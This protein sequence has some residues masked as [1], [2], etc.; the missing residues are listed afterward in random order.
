MDADYDWLLAAASV[1]KNPLSAQMWSTSG[2]ISV[3]STK[4]ILNIKVFRFD[5]ELLSPS[6]GSERN[7][8]VNM[9]VTLAPTSCILKKQHSNLR[10][11]WK[12][13]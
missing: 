7:Y 1:V 8:T 4:K 10:T 12:L 6:S 5:E 2:Q 11:H 13:L 9:L 3:K